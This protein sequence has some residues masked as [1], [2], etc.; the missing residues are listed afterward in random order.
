[1][2]IDAAPHAISAA[3]EM[4]LADAPGVRELAVQ[5]VGVDGVQPVERQARGLNEKKPRSLPE[6]G[7]WDKGMPLIAITSTAG[8]RDL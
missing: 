2:Q 3:S 4:I 7:G 8:R 5:A 6:F 1:M